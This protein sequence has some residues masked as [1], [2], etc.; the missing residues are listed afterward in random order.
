MSS[1]DEPAVHA[2]GAV[3][4]RVARRRLEVLLVHR[5][6]YDDWSWPKGKLEPGETLPA[7]AAREVEEETGV[8]VVLGQ[9]LGTVRYRTRDRRRKEAHYWAATPAEDH[10]RACLQARPAVAAADPREVDEARWVDVA[11][12]R[13]LL[14]YAHDRDPLGVLE[15]Q[16]RDE[17]LRTWTMVVLRHSRAKKRSAWKGGEATRPL[18]TVGKQRAAELVPVI[19]AYG[20]VEVITSPW[21]RC[22]ATVRPYLEASGVGA[23]LHPELT[24]AAHEKSKR[25]VRELIHRELTERSAPVVVCTHR[26]VLPTVVAEVARRTPNRIMK[27]VPESD[28]WLKTSELLVVHVA[29]RPRRGAVVVALEKHRPSS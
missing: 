23:E 10:D 2:A 22:A 21:E 19:A 14:T 18:T 5:P 3:V 7:C 4:W 8:A 17:K 12:A 1:K 20:V 11:T 27:Q 16:W 13:S 28:P 24:E 29:K 26:P 9:P 15:D 6:R 25:P